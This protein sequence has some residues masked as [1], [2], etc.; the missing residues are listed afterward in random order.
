MCRLI[1]IKNLFSTL[2]KRGKKA[3]EEKA[4]KKWDAIVDEL[5]NRK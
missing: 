2:I 1:T 3:E 5:R 4:A